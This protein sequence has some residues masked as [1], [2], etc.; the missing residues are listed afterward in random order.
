MYPA[1]SIRPTPAPPHPSV[2]AAQ[3]SLHAIKQAHSLEVAAVFWPNCLFADKDA[4]SLQLNRTS[5]PAT[6]ISG[7]EQTY[8]TQTG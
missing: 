8:R 3:T 4:V 7:H 5:R 6:L 2:S 1:L